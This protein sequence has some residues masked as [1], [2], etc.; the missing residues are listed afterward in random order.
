MTAV[1]LA[2]ER[3]DLLA[4][5]V[6]SN[7]RELARLRYGSVFR[8]G[9]ATVVLN[10]DNPLPAASFAGALDGPPDAVEATLARLPVVFAEAGLPLTTVQASPTSSPELE[11]LVEEL[12]YEASDE[13]AV[14]VLTDPLALMEGEP[15]RLVR[16]VAEDDEWRIARLLGDVAGWPSWV[17]RR[18]TTVLGHRLDDPRYAA[19]GA[20]DDDELV[21]VATAFVWN[22]LGGVGD[23]AVRAGHRG[24]R[25]GRALVSAASSHCLTRQAERVWLA[26]DAVGTRSRF[27]A[28]CGFEPAYDVVT[29]DRLD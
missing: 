14:H 21:G 26:G 3:L 11:L 15:G 4:Q 12:G 10:P 2:D 29:Y 16:P 17:E 9:V 24:R 18:L 20:Y 28:A 27:W 6:E 7:A 19:F 25:L 5:R 8:A 23:V 13:H 22:G 1:D